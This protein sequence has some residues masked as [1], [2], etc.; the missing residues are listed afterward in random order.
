MDEILHA[1]EHSVLHALTDTLKL[2]PFLF[3]TYLLMEFLE[4]RA[5]GATERWLR[6][7]GCVG[8]LFGGV[9]GMLPQCGF[10]AAAAGLYAGLGIA[11]L[12][13][14][15]AAVG[16]TVL[17]RREGAKAPPKTRAWLREL[18]CSPLLLYVILMLL[19]ACL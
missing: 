18:L 17:L 9:L 3:L 5:G 15:L 1:L 14:A 10:S 11:A 7:A 12:L 2:I 16:L 4:H 19:Y 6:R 13:F 8:P